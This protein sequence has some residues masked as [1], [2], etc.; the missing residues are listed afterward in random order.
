M[1]KTSLLIIFAVFGLYL[2]YGIVVYL[3]LGLRTLKL[4]HNNK[5][6]YFFGN[7]IIG[8]IYG[9]ILILNLFLIFLINILL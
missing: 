5:R 3:I 2:V 9:I 4:Y 7:F 8:F 1:L 6:V